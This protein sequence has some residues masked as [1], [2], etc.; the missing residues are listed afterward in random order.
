MILRF[1]FTATLGAVLLVIVGW[2]P[3]CESRGADTLDIY[4][5]NAGRAKGA[6]ATILVAPSGQS[7]MLDA[8]SPS[9]APRVLVRS[10]TPISRR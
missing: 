3:L 1:G 7:A 8:G 6:N 2:L 5:V 10:T 9:Q 4:F